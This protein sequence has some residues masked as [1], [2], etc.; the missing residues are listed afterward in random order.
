MPD[1]ISEVVQYLHSII[2]RPEESGLTDGE[3]LGRFIEQRD[4]TA[5]AALMHR[6][7]PMV[8]GVC[9]RLVANHHDAEAAFQATFLVLVRR[10]SF[11]IPRERVGNWL[12]GVA[13][14]TSLKAGARLAKRRTRERQ[15]MTMPEAPAPEQNPWDDLQPLLDQ[16]LSRLPEKYRVAIVLCDLEGNTRKE[17]AR[18]LGV[19]EGTLA[20]WLTRGRAL[21]AKRLTR[22]RALSGGAPAAV[23]TP[24]AS[25]AVPTSVMSSATQT[26]LPVA[27]GQAVAGTASVAVAALT[28]GVMKAMWM[29]RVQVV[30]RA[31]LVGALLVG[32]A[33]GYRTLADN[34]VPPAGKKTP[35]SDNK[36]RDTLL[37]LDKQL[38][39]ATSNY[40]VDTLA[41]LLAD[42]Y[43]AFSPD[44]R[45]W[46]K[47]VALERYRQ[48]RHI[49]VKFST[50]RSVIPLN[51]D[52]AILS[53]E[54]VWGAEDKG[55][56][57]RPGGS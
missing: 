49:N 39:E 37:V 11:I 10:A 56:G 34:K 27:A 24:Q 48:T 6:H 55:T 28:E 54:V 46:T 30:L 50:G 31:C 23:L 22:H 17:T 38:W 3:L 14:Q 9:R 13:H 19:P 4:T 33:F 2:L 42:D 57:V 36:L 25:P 32:G 15:M 5:V 44:G 20:G 26:V 12:Y 51:E 18:Q 7:G 8:W 1:Q 45:H 21:L 40:A 35:A 29:T 52:T 43:L 16:E 41:K 53:Y 47:K